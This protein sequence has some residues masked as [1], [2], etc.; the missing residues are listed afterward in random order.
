MKAEVSEVEAWNNMKHQ[1]CKYFLE[2]N[3][4]QQILHEPI[5][6]LPFE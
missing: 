4:V 5:V 2:L 1:S 3:I 6:V